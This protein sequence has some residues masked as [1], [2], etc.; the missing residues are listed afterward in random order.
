MS[1]LPAVRTRGCALTMSPWSWA[2]RSVDAIKAPSQRPRPAP[3]TGDRNARRPK[4][5][6]PPTPPVSRS[7]RAPGTGSA[8]G[9]GSGRQEGSRGRWRRAGGTGVGAGK[10]VHPSYDP[11][12]HE[13]EGLALRGAEHGY[14]ERR[15]IR[16][17]GHR[18][19]SGIC[20][21]WTPSATTYR[22]GS[23]E[24]CCSTT[25]TRASARGGSACGQGGFG[26]GLRRSGRPRDPLTG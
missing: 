10:G 2:H 8:P 12:L 11:A 22:A 15:V 19:L 26:R 6:G 3:G 4:S 9:D 20:F 17:W 23:T 14:A 1:P 21:V 24:H 5:R 18:R 7:T 16:T 25:P 13:G